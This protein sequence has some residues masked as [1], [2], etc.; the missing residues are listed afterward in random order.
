MSKMTDKSKKSKSSAHKQ[1][2]R[3]AILMLG[4]LAVASVVVLGL[5]VL[6][7]NTS[8][9][10]PR[11]PNTVSA[12]R[13]LGQASAPVKIDLYADIQCPLCL[14][15]ELML[16]ELT[17]KYIDTGNV[18]VI[19][20]NFAF[21]GQESVWAAQAA[22]CANDQGRFWDMTAYLFDQQTG[23]NV[24]TFSQANLKRYAAELQLDTAAFN[25]CLDSGKHASLVQSE[26]EA[27]RA[28]G[29]RATPSF[30]VNGQFI[31]GMMPQARFVA[32]LESYLPKP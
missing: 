22:E 14:R 32:I 30:F 6:N 26:L 16:R 7:L 5:V 4:V 29:V 3:T 21:L 1:S 13:V 12:G 17:P 11:T 23:E 27:G 8:K 19:F 31:E 28:L 25:A 2:N 10:V 18:Q 15:A 20:H 24:G 9:P